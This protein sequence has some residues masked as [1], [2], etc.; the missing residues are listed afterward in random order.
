MYTYVVNFSYNHVYTAVTRLY[1]K[2]Q[3][4]GTVYSTLAGWIEYPIEYSY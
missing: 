3:L 4:D 2:T 1:G